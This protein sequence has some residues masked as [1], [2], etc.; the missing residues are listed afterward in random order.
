MDHT[1]IHFGFKAVKDKCHCNTDIDP[2]K[3][4]AAVILNPRNTHL[5]RRHEDNELCLCVEAEFDKP[6]GHTQYRSKSHHYCLF[7]C[8]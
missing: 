7:P 4:V 1:Q 5:K 6:I 3:L 8:A 2:D